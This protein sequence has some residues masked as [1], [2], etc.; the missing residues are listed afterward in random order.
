MTLLYTLSALALIAL[1]GGGGY[2]IVDRYF[3]DVT[4]LALQHK[5]THEFHILAAPIPLE[6]IPADRDWSILRDNAAPLSRPAASQ[7]PITRDQATH[8]AISYHGGGIV[9]DIKITTESDRLS[10][11]VKFEDGDE[12]YLDAYS[13]DLINAKVLDDVLSPSQPTATPVDPVASFSESAYDAEL[14]AI[15]VLP[16]DKNGRLLFDPN[17]YA[18]PLAPDKDALGVALASGRDLRTITLADGS[19]VR[20]LTYRLTRSDGPAALQLGRVLTDQEHVLSELLIVLLALSG[21]SLVILGAGSWWLAGRALSPAQQAW[22]RQQSFVASASH[23]LRTPLTLMRASAEVAMRSIE[24]ESADQRELLGDVL[25]EADHMRRLVDDL[26]TLSRLD[27]GRLKLDRS[28]VDLTDL[29]GDIQRQVGRISG[30]RG[31]AISL[32]QVAGVAIADA[33]RLRQVLLILLDNAMRYTPAGGQIAL[34]AEQ[35]GQHIQIQVAD[36]GSGIPPEHLPHVFERFYRADQA[37]GVSGNAGLGLPIAKGLIDAQQGKIGI[38]SALGAGTT[39]TITLQA[40][41]SR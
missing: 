10:Y 13:G 14:A 29:L 19:R 17:P 40:L 12:Y 15:F 7:I 20:M 3:Q 32:G 18:P 21:V 36:S 2:L 27:S 6:L 26:L 25:T 23:E 28:P 9:H 4:D 37:R 24:G 33:A 16:L 34:S 22:E 41:P 30:E 8:L 31:I 35:R 39:V 38:A 5:M 11:E 1:V